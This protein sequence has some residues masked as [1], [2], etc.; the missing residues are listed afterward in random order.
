MQ[1][2]PPSKGPEVRFIP[3]LAFI[4]S[5]S[6]RWQSFPGRRPKRQNAGG[7]L[8]LNCIVRDDKAT[9]V[10]IQR[11]GGTYTSLP[12]SLHRCPRQPAWIQWQQGLLSLDTQHS[13]AIDWHQE[14]LFSLFLPQNPCNPLSLLHIRAPGCRW[15]LWAVA[16]QVMCMLKEQKSWQHRRRWDPFCLFIY[17]FGGGLS[18]KVTR[19]HSPPAATRA[20]W[21]IC[22][23]RC[24]TVDNLCVSDSSL[25]FQPVKKEEPYLS[26]PSEC[27]GVNQSIC[28]SIRP[29]IHPTTHW[30]EGSGFKL[31]W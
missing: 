10:C 30:Q 8:S 4:L 26:S 29:S 15:G 11:M 7:F 18:P 1:S 6:A 2:V 12:A 31:Y 23:V 5:N 19:L 27:G 16:P 20:N 9:L 22:K 24:H 3:I 13:S 28:L 14:L 21:H 25:T 17:F